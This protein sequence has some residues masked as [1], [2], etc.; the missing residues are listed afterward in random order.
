MEIT[1][2]LSLEKFLDFIQFNRL[3]FRQVDKFEPL[4]GNYTEKMYNLSKGITING[5]NTGLIERTKRK[6]VFNYVNCW[7]QS[8]YECMAMWQIYG[9]K[10]GVAIQ[11]TVS[12]LKNELENAP[13]R[14]NNN[15]HIIMRLAQ[16]HVSKVNYIDHRGENLD[17]SDALKILD[18][19]IVFKNVGYS[20]EREVRFLYDIERIGNLKAP[21]E[22]LGDG[23]YINIDTKKIVKKILV[24]PN[25]DEL[26]FNNVKAILEKYGFDDDVLNWSS[27]RL[28]AYNETEFK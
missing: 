25:A 18:N 27:L 8:K 7:T 28:P 2:Y 6:R 23:F 11:T 14:H 5:S 17:S 10:N 13:K 3:C 12:N 20:H 4:E 24:A 16:L 9:G 19:P 26:H 21:P 15:V 22:P 1:R